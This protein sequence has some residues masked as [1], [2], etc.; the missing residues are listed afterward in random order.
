MPSAERNNAAD[1]CIFI[2]HTPQTAFGL[3]KC[4]AKQNVLDWTETGRASFSQLIPVI[5]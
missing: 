5:S 2:D 4:L 1:G 3:P